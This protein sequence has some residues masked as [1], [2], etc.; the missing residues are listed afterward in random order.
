M[1]S[2][3]AR[4]VL[5]GVL[6]ALIAVLVTAFTVQQVTT[7]DI[8]TSVRRDLDVE[9]TIRD[10]LAF[11]GAETG[12]WSGVAA[13][14]VMLSEVFDE[15]IA[16]AT[17]DGRILADSERERFDREVPLPEGGTLIDPS[18][19]LLAFEV[20]PDELATL[21]SEAQAVEFCLDVL[22]VDASLETDATGL[23]VIDV[24]FELSDDDAEDFDECV[25]D[26]L[27]LGDTSFEGFDSDFDDG[28]AEPLLLFIGYAA[29]SEAVSEAG[30]SPAFWFAVACILAAVAVV[31]VIWARR[32]A[33]P[34]TAL[35]EAAGQMATGDLDTRVNV[36]GAD[37]LVELGEAFNHM[38]ASLQAEDQARRTLTTDV[39]HELRTP[40]ANLRGYLKAI[41]DGVVEA[42]EVTI[43][44]LHDEAT[45]LQNL[46]ADL[47]QLS[48]AE[49]SRLEIR[50]EPTDMTALLD[51]LG[52]AHL[53][54]ATAAE[55]SLQVESPRDGAGHAVL[56]LVDPDRVR[57]VLTNLIAN[58]INHT[59]AG[60][61]VTLRAHLATE[62]DAAGKRVL[63]EVADT[64]VGIAAEHL[65][66]LFD[67]FYRPD[68]SRSRTTGGTGLGLAIAKELTDA[69]GGDL[70]VASQVGHGSTFTLRLPGAT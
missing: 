60:G 29:T 32:V 21:E 37:E 61:T 20:P 4:L 44:S 53:A 9:L 15:R 34:I 10:S 45:S 3:R 28:A 62:A 22:G 42:D 65:P 12:S 58:A 33:Q 16:I 48:L 23:P 38:A 27:G 36:T 13:E 18:G 41:Q 57:Q 68:S 63:V 59:P 50:A 17:I 39:A 35:T 46:V 56:A 2:L 69:L 51:R 1:S 64:G 55:V 24:P 66:R 8:E 25:I 6:V 7:S 49:A 70:S 30:T 47:Q 14:V 26:F 5:L 11:Y 31:T 54:T 43:A 40:L 52:A 19:A 67:R